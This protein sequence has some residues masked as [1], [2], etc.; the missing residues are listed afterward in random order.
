MTGALGAAVTPETAPARVLQRF[1]DRVEIRLGAPVDG[2][3]VPSVV[4]E[5]SEAVLA[6]LS[7]TE[8][9]GVEALL[10]RSTPD[11]VAG[12]VNRVRAGEAWDMPS[13]APAPAQSPQAGS[14]SAPAPV[15]AGTSDYLVGTVALGLV[16]VHGPDEETRFTGDEEAK[17]FA[18]VQAGV[19]WLAGFNPAA[20][21]SFTWDYRQI[22][23]ETA[24]D[25][26]AVDNETRFR[27]PALARIGYPA[28]MAGVREYLNWLRT[29]K[30]TDWAYC[31][32]FVNG[33]PVDHF[34]YASIGGPRMVMEY[35]NDGWGP[36]NIDRVFAHETGHIFGCPDEYAESNCNCGGSWGRY[37]EPNR[38][39]ENGA[40]GGGVGCL[41][42]ANEWLMCESTKK[43]LGWP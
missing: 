8:R 16:V 28:G 30:K 2:I 24:R 21:V 22:M 29:S 14:A 26:K 40:V 11:Y 25:A 5:V 17:M 38:N 42:R 32:F 6:S 13:C 43:H 34:A 39:C 35:A 3:S 31:L 10:L 36:D 15:A 23:I 33:Y 18:E 27:D 12:K 7:V 37:G 20:N 9:L 4:P 41:M 1:G 19:S